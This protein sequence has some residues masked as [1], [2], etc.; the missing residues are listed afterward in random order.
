MRLRPPRPPVGL[1]MPAL[2]LCLTALAATGCPSP[3][4]NKCTIKAGEFNVSNCP[5]GSEIVS[6]ELQATGRFTGHCPTD[7]QKKNCT[8]TETFS[9][10]NTE[11]KHTVEL[12]G[13]EFDD[14]DGL[15]AATVTV[16]LNPPGGSCTVSSVDLVDP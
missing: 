15:S 2:G 10:T 12:D 1:L 9:S 6:V 16:T 3:G 7:D 13:W 4:C 14:D 11:G 8:E 5:D